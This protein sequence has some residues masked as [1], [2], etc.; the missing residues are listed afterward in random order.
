MKSFEY[1]A[2]KTL[3]EAT[4]LLAEH[5]DQGRRRTTRLL[6]EL[7]RVIAAL[8]ARDITVVLL[9][10]ADT[11]Q[12]Y[13]PDPGTRPMADVDLLVAPER[14]GATREVLVS[15]GF[16]Q[17]EG[18]TPPHRTEW[19]Q[20]GA[21][22]EVQSLL[23]NHVENPWA[24][25]LHTT[26]DRELYPGLGAAFGPFD[27]EAQQRW[28]GSARTRALRQPLLLAYLACNASQDFTTLQ[29]VR[30]V[31]LVFVI[32]RDF[33]GRAQAW[34]AFGAFV[35][36]TGTGRFVYPSLELAD[37]LVP[38]TL[39]PLVRR[40]LLP[41]VPARLRRVVDGT[42]VGALIRYHPMW[43]TARLM[44]ARRPREYLAYLAYLVWPRTPGGP[45]GLGQFFRQQRR[46]LSRLLDT[47]W[48]RLARR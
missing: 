47:S 20:R 11:A 40:R 6:G 25:D 15:L 18:M 26:V 27:V 36:E 45:V 43:V 10:G 33:A 39:D 37:R 35:A 46:R 12:R 42:D 5:L 14:C 48:R 44:W 3:K 13:F 2:P 41:A 28:N 4:A 29:L 22:R 19:L 32:R 31:E 7:D 23:V 9:K 30:L 1:A 38:G 34:D 8:H 21:S 24:L 16:E 17:Q